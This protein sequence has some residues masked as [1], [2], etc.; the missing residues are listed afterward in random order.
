M[1]ILKGNYPAPYDRFKNAL[2]THDGVV[3]KDTLYVVPEQDRNQLICLFHDSHGHQGIDPTT[4]HLRQLCWWPSLKEDVTHYVENCLICAQNNPDRYAKKAQLS[5]T[6]PVNGPWTNLQIDFIGPLPPCR[7]G[8]K[9]VLV[10]I[11]TFTK[12]VEA[13]PSRT[14]TAKTTAKILTH[15]IFTRW[16]LPRSI[17]SDQGSHFTERVMKNVLTIFGIIQKFHI[18]Y[19]PQSSGIVERM[20]RTLKSTLRKMVQQNNTTWDSVLPFALMFLR[21]TVSTSTGY[22]PHTLMTGR[23]M[24]GTELLLGLDLTSPEV[25]ALTHENA[26][27]Q[28]VENVK[29]AQLAAAVRLGTRKKQ[30]K[31]CFDKTVHATEFEVG[32]QVMLSIY[33]P[34]TFL[35]QKY[36]GPYSIADKVSPSVKKLSTP[37]ER[38]RGSILTSLRHM[39]HSPTTHT[40]SCST[41]QTTPCPHPTYPYPPPTRPPHP[42]T[43]P[44]LHPRPLDSALERP[45][46]A[47]TVTQTI[48]TARLPTIP[49][50]QDPHPANLTTIRVIPSSSLSSTNTLR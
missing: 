43:R 39:A 9:Y 4:A 45:Q 5:H 29:T 37:T 50:Q 42:R 20:N 2:T 15:H 10:V 48:A 32:Q 35:S 13:F 33:N 8:Y 28:L 49:R 41:Q 44:R 16:G 36:S 46:A 21:N 18:A 30:S 24:E 11:D 26:V 34:S 31:A 38:L 27:K 19:H 1:E 12:W 22:T 25:T 23:P 6:R 17:E 14:N 40:T 7:N 3:L 47:A